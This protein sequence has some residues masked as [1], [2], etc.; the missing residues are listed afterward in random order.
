MSNKEKILSALK[1]KSLVKIISGIQNY[2]KQKTL[3]VAMAGELGGATCIDISDDEEIIKTVRASV[4]VPLFF[5][6][7]DPKKLI[8]AQELGADV[9]EI[10]N[11]EPYYK[12]GRLFTRKEITEIV[13]A[14]KIAQGRNVLLCCTVPGTLEIENQVKLANVLLNL[15]VDILQ[16][17]GFPPETPVSDRSDQAF[18]EILQ[19]SSTLANLIELRKTLKDVPI[20]CASGITPRTLPFVFAGGASGV[21]IGTYIN[22][23]PSQTLMQEKIE[24]IMETIKVAVKQTQSVKELALKL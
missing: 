2:D 16:T 7:V 8:R 3:N 14:V 10:G 11:Y 5:S 12:E 4:E 6:S 9:L 18:N 1:N 24:E 20:I 13:K 22:S 17:E 21:G 15:G 19:S 23:L